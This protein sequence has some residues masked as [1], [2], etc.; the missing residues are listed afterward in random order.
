MQRIRRNQNRVV[1]GVHDDFAGDVHAALDALIL[2]A[3]R[4]GHVV[5]RHAGTRVA[6]RRNLLHHAS[7]RRVGQRIDGERH[8]LSR[9]NGA[10]IQLVNGQRERQPR[11]RLDDTHQLC[12]VRHAVALARV[13]RRHNAVARRGDRQRIPLSVGRLQ[14]NQRLVVIAQHGC[15]IQIQRDFVPLDSRQ[16]VIALASVADLHQQP[17]D[18]AAVGG[19]GHRFVDFKRPLA[20][21]LPR[22]RIHRHGDVHVI[23]VAGHFDGRFR[24]APRQADHLARCFDPFAPNR[25]RL[26]QFE[27][28]PGKAA[29]LHL[30]LAVR[31]EQHHRAVFP[32]D[33]QRVVAFFDVDGFNQ[34]VRGRA[35]RDFV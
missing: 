20:D 30:H 2:A 17:L 5:G 7:Q 23:F 14:R 32:V 16:R 19:N 18:R 4:H 28:R 1:F 24:A 31:R 21:R 29:Q 6:Q 25:D 12:A 13:N 15:V 9:L 10:D 34:P 22:L 11:V 27:Q 8:A 33:G 3:H 26:P 35:D